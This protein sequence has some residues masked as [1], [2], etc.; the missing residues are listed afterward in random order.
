MIDP[1]QWRGFLQYFR[2][3]AVHHK[4]LGPHTVR[5]LSAN[6]GAFGFLS[7]GSVA[8]RTSVVHIDVGDL[9]VPTIQ[10][11][12]RGEEHTSRENPPKMF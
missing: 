12:H 10:R 4:K 11:C 6:I 1:R 2:V 8:P 5:S 3:T 7:R 9:P